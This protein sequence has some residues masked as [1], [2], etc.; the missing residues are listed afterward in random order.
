[1]EGGGWV[2][3]AGAGKGEGPAHLHIGSRVGKES[4]GGAPVLVLLTLLLPRLLLPR[5]L[6][7]LLL[8]LL[9]LLPSLRLLGGFQGLLP[10]LLL[11][12]LLLLL[13][14]LLP[15]ALPVSGGR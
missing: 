7:P 5:L 4:R 13:L 6:L 11:P 9:L 15:L 3:M 8:L 1:M 14:L 2:E 12:L 10:L